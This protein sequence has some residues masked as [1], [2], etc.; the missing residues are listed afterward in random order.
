[1]TA[2][3][4]KRWLIGLVAAVPVSRTAGFGVDPVSSVPFGELPHRARQHAYGLRIR[5]TR[6]ASVSLRRRR[7]LRRT[8]CCRR[9]TVLTCSGSWAARAAGSSISRRRSQGPRSC[10]HGGPPATSMAAEEAFN[11]RDGPPRG[12]TRR[13]R[14]VLA[15][16]SWARGSGK[17]DY[18]GDVVEPPKEPGKR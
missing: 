15:I 2:A 12:A 16:S 4:K 3:V 1:M 17:Q 9:C 13:M 10:D 14:G 6:I 18:T 7:L 5:P 8:K 11:R